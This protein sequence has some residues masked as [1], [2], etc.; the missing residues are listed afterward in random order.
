MKY[1]KGKILFFFYPSPKGRRYAN[2]L[3]TLSF[4]FPRRNRRLLRLPR[5]PRNRLPQQGR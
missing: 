1:E 5:L 3:H 4:R 2:I